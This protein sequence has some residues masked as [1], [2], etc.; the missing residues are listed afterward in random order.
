[1]AEGERE[2]EEEMSGEDFIKYWGLEGSYLSTLRVPKVVMSF[3]SDQFEQLRED[4]WTFQTTIE[5]YRI[6]K[7]ESLEKDN[8]EELEQFVSGYVW[9][10]FHYFYTVILHCPDDETLVRKLTKLRRNRVPVP[11][12]DLD[13]LCICNGPF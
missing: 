5:D 6:S 13:M 1:M 8:Y 4:L 11:A 9:K 7:L 3:E 10:T 12:F 2:I